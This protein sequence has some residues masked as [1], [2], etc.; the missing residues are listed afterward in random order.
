MAIDK[1]RFN[2]VIDTFTLRK[3]CSVSADAES[4]ARG[5]SKTVTLEVLF[6]GATINDLAM[7]CLG[8]GKVVTWQNGYARKHYN[9]LSDR[10]VVKIT[11]NKPASAPEVDGKT[12]LLMEAKA[13]GVDITD[14]DALMEYVQS[15]FN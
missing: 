3:T 14:K 9:E 4:K 13:A 8:Q 11:W 10:Q 5:E 7:S 1:S 6:D 12:K 2:E 15:Q